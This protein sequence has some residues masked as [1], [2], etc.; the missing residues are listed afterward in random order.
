MVD[1]IRKTK[2]IYLK[3][4]TCVENTHSTSIYFDELQLWFTLILFKIKATKSGDSAE[5]IQYC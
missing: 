2:P 3:V 5:R 4:M 1:G